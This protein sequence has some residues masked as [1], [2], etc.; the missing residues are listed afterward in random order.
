MFSKKLVFV[1]MAVFA[2]LAISAFLANLPE[3]KDPAVMA[4]IEPYF[5]YT[6]TKTL[7][8]LDLIDKH[9][10]KKL[11]LDNAKVFLAYDH[12]LKRWGE[13]HL[14]LQGSTLTLTDD[15]GS[16]S[17]LALTPAQR[18]FVRKF[19]FQQPSQSR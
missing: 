12:Y 11:K 10:G 8:G 4:F 9:T 18:A 1:L 15:N 13:K 7:G 14:K 2:F 6:F 3:K 16:V 19:F 5:P 17:T